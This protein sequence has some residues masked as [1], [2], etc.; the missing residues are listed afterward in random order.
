MATLATKAN[1]KPHEMD[2]AQQT[3]NDDAEEALCPIK[4]MRI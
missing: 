4:E 1:A 2:L 3:E